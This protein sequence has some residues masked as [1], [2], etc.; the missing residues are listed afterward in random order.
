VACGMGASRSMSY[1]AK[2]R[3]FPAHGEWWVVLWPFRGH[4][5]TK[6]A[7]WTDFELKRWLTVFK[8]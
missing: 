8:R 7:A 6:E 4:G 3:I 5:A 1:L 2:P